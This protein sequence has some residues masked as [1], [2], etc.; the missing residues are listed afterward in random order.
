MYRIIPLR[1]LHLW[2]FK[3]PTWNIKNQQK[4]KINSKEFHLTIV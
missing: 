4:C 3:T 2:K 1:I